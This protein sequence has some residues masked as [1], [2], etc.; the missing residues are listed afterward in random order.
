MIKIERAQIPE[1]EMSESEKVL[2]ERLKG[3]R[4]R[5]TIL[6][7]KYTSPTA[8][9]SASGIVELKAG[10]S[11]VNLYLA[12]ELLNGVIQMTDAVNEGRY[13]EGFNKFTDSIELQTE[14]LEHGKPIRPED[15]IVLPNKDADKEF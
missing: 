11:K 1:A 14:L 6:Y 15:E 12:N 5:L 3:L 9:G 10:A 8:S 2:S 7:K 13:E 4:D